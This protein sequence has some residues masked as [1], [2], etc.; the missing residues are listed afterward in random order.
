MRIELVNIQ[1]IAHA[2]YDIPETGVTQIKGENS[3]GKSILIKAVAFVAKTLIE[4]ARER[5]DLIKDGTSF[6]EI[7]ME[8][9]DFKLKV[10]IEKERLSSYYEF[11]NIKTGNSMKRNPREG[12]LE[13]IAEAFGFITF[14]KQVSLQ[15]F[16]TF[17]VMPFVN[18]TPA[19][20]YQIMDYVISDEVGNDFVEKFT[21]ITYPLFK[22]YVGRLK[23]KKEAAERQLE[24]TTFYD[25]DKYQGI[26]DKL[27]SY[28]RNVSNLVYYE[29]TEIF[30]PTAVKY[31]EV[32]EYNPTEVPIIHLIE[33]LEAKDITD[34]LERY[35]RAVNGRC[36]TC[37]TRFVDMKEDAYVNI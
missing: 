26:V 35:L 11:S 1:S 18:C 7:I 29:P 22:E 31:A 36:P 28:Y 10:H 33:P 34:E 13:Q 16:E 9:G 21:T 19:I 12:G 15:I 30:V 25:I 3:N 6:G 24:N 27:K 20:D 17:G 8:R 5:E 37:N 23:I 2:V 32:P 4:D 14:S